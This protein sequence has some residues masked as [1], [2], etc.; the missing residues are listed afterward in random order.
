MKNA[1]LLQGIGLGFGGERGI[2]GMIP[3]EEASNHSLRWFLFSFKPLK[4]S[5]RDFPENK[6]SRQGGT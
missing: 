4:A 5:F 6:K 3:K 2:T 1:P